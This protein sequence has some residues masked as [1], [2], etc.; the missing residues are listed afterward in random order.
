MANWQPLPIMGGAYADDALPWS[1]QDTVNYL[2]VPAER[3]GTRSPAKLTGAPGL[4]EYADLGTGLPVRGAY[5][6]EGQLLAVSDRTLFRVGTDGTPTSIGTIPGTGRVVMAH[7]QI[8]GGHEVAIANGLSGYVYNTVTGV[9]SQ[10]TDDGFPGWRTVDYV[11]GYFAGVEPAGRYWF[12]SDLRAG[13]SY[14]T[15]DRQDAEAAPDKLVGLIVS[16]REVMVGGARSAQFFRNTGA[17]TGTF[18]NANGTEMEVG[19]AS[20]YAIARLDNTVYWLGHDGILYRLNGN[21]PQRISTGPVEQSIS[22]CDISR[23]FAFTFEDR[24]HKV[25]Y[26]TFPDGPTWGYDVWSGEFH[27]RESYGLKRWRLNTLTRSRGLWI[28]GDYANGKLY[29]LDWNE[30][31]ED[32]APLVARRRTAVMH[33]DGNTIGIKGLK[34]TFDAGRAA[35]GVTDRHASIRYSDDGGHTFSD[36]RIASIGAAGEYRTEVVEW[37]LGRAQ[38]RVWEVEVASPAKRDLLA[39]AV[40][41][42]VLG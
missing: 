33:A 42:E 29:R 4:V 15:L 1:A 10:I 21:Q 27:R 35:V 9:L 25:F 26:L 36:A 31:H 7:N 19:L 16:R 23:A 28:G 34:L 41:V 40:Q 24:G 14:N 5:D 8:T 37:R 6:V 13:T 20:P 18:Q 38:T 2:L 17:T 39:A 3:E 11:D 22:E 32:G 12:H 30:M